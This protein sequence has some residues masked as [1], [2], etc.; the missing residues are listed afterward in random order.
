MTHAVRVPLATLWSDPDDRTDANVVTQ[1]PLGDAAS[2]EEI[3]ADGWA[4]VRLPDQ[5]DYPGWLPLAQLAEASTPDVSSV[6]MVDAL[7]ADLRDAP[8]G[9]LAMPGVPLGTRLSAAG[10]PEGGWLPVCVPGAAKPLW[11]AESDV[12]AKPADPLATARR[13]LGVVYVWGG[14]SPGG[15]DCSGL[16]HLAW[17][18]HGV[19][20]PRDA[21]QQADAATPLAPG[22]ERAG[23]LYFFAHPGRRVHH[24]GIVVEPGVMLHACGTARSVVEGPLTPDRAATLTLVARPAARAGS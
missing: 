10:P 16:V 19:R 2:V 22:E 8:N 4:R 17:R 18:C 13:L 24:V 12:C 23:D 7:F 20:L 6:S 3:R 21:H 5:G 15:I 14:L 9:T 1:A 11:V